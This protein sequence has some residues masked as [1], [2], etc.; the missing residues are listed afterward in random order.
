MNLKSIVDKLFGRTF[1]SP[2]AHILTY[3]QIVKY[4]NG[5]DPKWQKECTI[6]ILRIRKPD[7]DNP[8][9]SMWVPNMILDGYRPPPFMPEMEAIERELAWRTTC[10]PDPFTIRI[11]REWVPQPGLRNREEVCIANFEL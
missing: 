6:R 1:P 11:D 9:P 4:W 5:L 8:K 3:E 2:P 10:D 7:K